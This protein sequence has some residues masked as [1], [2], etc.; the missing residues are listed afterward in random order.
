MRRS[1]AGVVAMACALALLT[2]CTSP[3][4][5]DSSRSSV[6][7]I[8]SAAPTATPTPTPPIPTPTPTPDLSDTGAWVVDVDRVA[9]VEVGQSLASLAATAAIPAV[10]DTVDC[11]PGYATGFGTTADHP[12]SIALMDLEARGHA[13]A[14]PPFTYASFI[15]QTVA[16]APIAAS[17]STPA[18]I[19]LG[20]SESSLLNAYPALQKSHSRYDESMGYTTYA[21]GPIGG[22][23]LVFQV[24]TS[25][26]GSRSVVTIQ[27]STYPG[28]YDVCD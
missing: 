4:P 15:T 28:V 22:R 25:A 18:G 13:E 11:P 21:A 9:G 10:T 12:V 24:G 7:P 19:R 27:S 26:T 16:D 8:A 6:A 20:S 17:P 5:E 14:D 1:F 23:Y 3:A 2:G